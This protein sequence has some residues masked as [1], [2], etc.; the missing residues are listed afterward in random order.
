MAF[1]FGQFIGIV[2]V[3]V[4]LVALTSL[5]SAFTLQMATDESL[6]FTPSFGFSYRVSLQAGL[7]AVTICIALGILVGIAGKEFSV[8]G[9]AILCAIA[10]ITNASVLSAKLSHP[11][12]GAIGFGRACWLT[13]IQIVFSFMLVGAFI[14]LFEFITK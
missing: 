13:T 10:F 11:E 3:T 4:L 12:H 7:I 5:V 6:K 14:K 1:A 9:Y 2:L 8:A